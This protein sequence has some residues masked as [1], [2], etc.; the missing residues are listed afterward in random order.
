M[1]TTLNDIITKTL[2]GRSVVVYEYDAEFIYADN[3]RISHWHINDIDENKQHYN[4]PTHWRDLQVRKHIGTIVSVNGH[5]MDYEGTSISMVVTV[6]GN[7]E[8]VSIN[9]EDTMELMD[10]MKKHTMI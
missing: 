7:N 2:R 5:H 4:I 1:N 10:G 8:H 9:M 6:N 3:R